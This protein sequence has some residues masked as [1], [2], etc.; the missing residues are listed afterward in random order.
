MRIYQL[1][2]QLARRHDVTLLTYAE[3][4]H[5]TG[6]A[7]L[8]EQMSLRIVMRRPPSLGAKRLAQLRSV[9]ST[10]PFACNLLRSPEMQAAIDELCAAE[11]FDLIH[12]ESS[13]MACL[14]FPAGVPLLIDEH[15]IEYEL[16]E[17]LCRGERSPARKAF[18]WLEFVRFRRFEQESWRRAR[19]CVV[20]SER[21]RPTVTAA[22][23]RTSADVVPNAVD[24][25]YFAP[26][27]APVT[28]DTV[29]FNGIL[30]YR[31][32]LDAAQHLV[33]DVWPLVLA[34]RP[35]ARLQIVGRADAREVSLLTRPSVEV[36][37][38]VPD[39]RP[40]LR[41]AAAVAIPIRMGGGTRLKVVEA[42]SLG[43]AMVSTSIGCEGIAVHDREHLLIADGAEAFAAGIVELLED[44]PLRR[45]LGAAAR[46]RAEESYSWDL[47]G[48]RLEAVYRRIIAS[49]RVP[50]S[51]EP[52][53]VTAGG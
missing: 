10:L 52:Q 45:R 15:N 20:T 26:D 35:A 51:Q 31:P 43:K 32:N 49:T 39:I 33:E 53:R 50:A 8:A 24:L 2:R 6:I 12:V 34:R 1:A 7:G 44:E 38:T 14:R 28:P 9:A 3:E 5:E 29:V 19:A 27:P 42:M 25:D 30:N 47:A 21:E 23:P 36:T 46:A 18:Y 22:A 41:S 37:G 4:R 16:F 13:T 11:R 48:D 40:F 17:R